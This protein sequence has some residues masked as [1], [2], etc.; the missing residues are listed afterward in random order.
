MSSS[1]PRPLSEEEEVL[2]WQAPPLSNPTVGGDG[3]MPLLTADEIEA[4]QRQAW[5]EGYEE[6]RQAGL[7]AAE[8][9]SA[10]RIATLDRMLQ[11]MA[12]PLDELDE[13]VEEE[14]VALATAVA[15]QLI[16]R[17]VK[18]DPAQIVGVIREG[19]K[20]L[21]VAAGNIR[22]EL[23]PDDAALVR[24][25]LNLGEGEER[26]WHIHEDPT[27]TRGGC[28]IS[29]DTSRIDATLENRINQVVAAVLG[30]G[31]TGDRA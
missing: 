16:R 12:R 8:R 27:L 24:E 29:N 4:I 15:R 22:L 1:D 19:I 11:E 26:S 6:G 5:N 25:L 28:R 20:L 23:H 17:E 7:Q 18:T 14:L 10:E 13:R 2:S 21:P 3:G 30:E 31:R 9:E